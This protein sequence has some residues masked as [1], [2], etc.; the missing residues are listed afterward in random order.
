MK[1]VL[2]AAV[3]V[4]GFTFANAQ[5]TKFGAKAG[6]N[7][8]NLTGD[9]ETDAKVGFYV[10][11]FAEIKLTDKF[12]VQPEVMFSALGAKDSDDALNMNYIV[13]PVMAKYFITEELSLEA[14]PQI[15]F[16]MS[17]KVDGEDV[18]DAFTSTDFGFNF[19]AGY[20]VTENINVGLRY[21]L[22][23]SNVSDFDGADI[24]TSNFAL[25]VA[26]KF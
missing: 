22:G 8:S 2:F 17:A 24:K 11:G 25:G 12:A 9:A 18:K 6:L 19:G 23:L 5:E 3:A 4:L 26:Y 1:K 15:G 7:M 10:G 13:V 14:G 20:D 16:L 21:S